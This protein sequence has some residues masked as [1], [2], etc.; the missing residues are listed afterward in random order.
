MFIPIHDENPRLRVPAILVL[1]HWFLLQVLGGLPQL[2]GGSEAGV[3]FA[4]HVGGF[5]AGGLVALLMNRALHAIDTGLR[6]PDS[7]P[8]QSLEIASSTL[9]CYAA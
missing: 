5:V 1:G 7:G 8:H 2:S 3:A 9:Q 4:A 6:Q